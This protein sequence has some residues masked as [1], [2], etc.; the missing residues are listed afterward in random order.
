MYF[1]VISQQGPSWDPARTMREQQLWDEHVVFVNGLI[2]EGLLHLGGPLADGSRPDDDFSPASEPVG[3]DRIYRTMVVV[4]APG[5]GE[6]AARL[7]EDPWIRSG[8]IVRTS[9]DRWEVLVGDPAAGSDAGP[10][11]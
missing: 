3:D 11:P 10:Q 5:S 1:V 6:A 7:A 8:V 4:E 9:I 2:D